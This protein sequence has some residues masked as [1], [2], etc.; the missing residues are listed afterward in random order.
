MEV[1]FLSNM[2][3][4]LFVS[5]AEWKDWHVKLGKFWNYFEHASR[6]SLDV[7]RRPSGP[8]TPTSNISSPL[9]TPPAS[10]HASPPY[11]ASYSSNP[12]AYPYA[13]PVPAASYILPAVARTPELDQQFNPRKRSL[14]D[15]SHEPPPKRMVRETRPLAGRGTS[16]ISI[17]SY[18]TGIMA[19]GSSLSMQIPSICAPRSTSELFPAVSAPQSLPGGRAM[20]VS[21]V[22]QPAAVRLPVTLAPSVA[23]HSQ[24]SAN[25][26]SPY[27][28]A[29]RRQT[30]YPVSSVGSPASVYYSAASSQGTMSPSYILSH[31]NSPYRP[32]RDVSTLLGPP[33]SGFI[34]AAP[35][36]LPFDQMHYQPLAKSRGEYRTGVV[37]YLHHDAWPNMQQMPPWPTVTQS[38]MSR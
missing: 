28:E 29:S 18:S 3:Y 16:D 37:P 24:L 19:N 6:A 7:A 5:E 15:G 30:I 11:L 17:P 22:P 31:R 8:P 2:R 26:L 34:H 21:F 12:L 13:V 32:V 4:S 1:E 14:D 23:A 36:H 27:A 10:N 35:Q 20:S 25:N 38:G 9:P 33:R